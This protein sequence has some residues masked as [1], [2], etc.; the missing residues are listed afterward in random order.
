MVLLHRTNPNPYLFIMN[1]VDN[2]INADTPGGFDGW[3]RQIETYSIDVIV[4]GR[5]IK[6]KFVPKLFAWLKKH[7]NKRM[8]GGWTIYVKK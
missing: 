1:G 7:Y 8:I 3:L 5:Q 2:K 6:G 4:A